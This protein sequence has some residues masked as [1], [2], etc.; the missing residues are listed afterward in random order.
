MNI[1]KQNIQ[2]FIPTLYVGVNTKVP[3]KSS[4]TV[5]LEN[6]INLQSTLGNSI[7][8]LLTYYMV[9][10]LTL[11]WGA[12]TN[13][14]AKLT[15]NKRAKNSSKEKVFQQTNSHRT[16]TTIIAKS[17]SARTII[18]LTSIQKAI[19]KEMFGI[20]DE[21]RESDESLIESI[22]KELIHLIAQKGSGSTRISVRDTE[23]R[24]IWLR[25]TNSSFRSTLCAAPT[26]SPS[27]FSDL[28]D[29]R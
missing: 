28:N 24:G 7:K 20:N 4:S 1:K 16:M 13:I 23:S 3:E 21:E 26:F 6:I 15:V 17:I 27:K 29:I 22:N 9:L 2:Y 10:L 14:N 8:E 18:S 19:N 25:A 11:L 5:T 12:Q